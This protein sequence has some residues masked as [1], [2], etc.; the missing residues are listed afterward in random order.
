MT[1]QTLV[2]HKAQAERLVNYFARHHG[3]KLRHCHALEAVA[4]MTGHR[5]WNTLVASAQAPSASTTDAAHRQPDVARSAGP[6]TRAR[7]SA[8]AAEMA[9]VPA[10]T[11]EE[12]GAG[13]P[14]QQMLEALCEKK[15][16][17]GLFIVSGTCGSGMTT[18]LSALVR[19]VAARGGAQPWSQLAKAFG[20]A[21]LGQHKYGTRRRLD[22]TILVL[23]RGCAYAVCDEMRLPEEIDQAFALAKKGFR[24]LVGLHSAS[25]R[26]LTRLERIAPTSL[27][28][29]VASLARASLHIEQNRGGRMYHFRHL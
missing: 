22:E 25:E 7:N 20:V 2:E 24:V 13:R 4:Q 14:A 26:A 16:G 17:G 6:S 21:A 19:E 11:L 18:V 10:L 27:R 15:Q 8:L 29:E 5:D 23:R 12:L 9:Q 1:T 28:N 3:I